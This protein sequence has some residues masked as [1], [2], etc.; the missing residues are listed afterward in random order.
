MKEPKKTLSFEEGFKKLESIVEKMQGGSLPL[1]T[2][3][4]LFEEGNRLIEDMDHQLASAEKRVEKLLKKQD[5]SLQ[6]DSEGVVESEPF[7]TS[8]AERAAFSSS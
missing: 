2:S 3:L 5:G 7:E 8:E 6:L 1:E 4:N